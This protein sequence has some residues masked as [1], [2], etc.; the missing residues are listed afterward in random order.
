MY[1]H[2]CI[3][4]CIHTYTTEHAQVEGAS[5]RSLSPNSLQ[6]VWHDNFHKLLDYK[7]CEMSYLSMCVCVCV[8]VCLCVCVCVSVCVCECVCVCVCVC[9]CGCV[10]V[11]VCVRARVR[12]CM[13]VCVCTRVFMCVYVNVQSI[14]QS[15]L[16]VSLYISLFNS[17]HCNTLQH[18]ATHGNTRQHTATHSN[19]LPNLYMSLFHTCL[20]IRVICLFSKS[21]C[22][23][24]RRVATHMGWLRLVGSLK[25]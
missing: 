24:C 12:A 1:I 8:C 9:V 19:T 16:Y 2:I 7:V 25:F 3:F 14:Y 5:P 4:V 20:V 23:Y 13:C 17:S 21:A 6:A 22:K 18:A 10:W 15:V 11:C